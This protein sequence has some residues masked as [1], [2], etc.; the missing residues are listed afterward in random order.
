MS[1]LNDRAMIAFL[2]HSFTIIVRGKETGNNLEI[3]DLQCRSTGIRYTL[4]K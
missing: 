1:L 4:S 3:S 2:Y